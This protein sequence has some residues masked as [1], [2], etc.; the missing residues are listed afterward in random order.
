MSSMKSFFEGMAE[1]NLR[2]SLGKQSSQPY[3]AH[4]GRSKL[5][6]ILAVIG[7][8]I[9]AISVADEATGL[10]TV[11]FGAVAGCLIGFGLGWLIARSLRL[12][13]VVLPAAAWKGVRRLFGEPR[14]PLH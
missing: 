9:G 10:G 11:V 1:D 6:A 5:S 2:H 12:V 4:A 3:V 7:I 13:F 8:P 14:K